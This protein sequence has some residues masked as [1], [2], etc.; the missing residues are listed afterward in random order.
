MFIIDNIAYVYIIFLLLYLQNVSVDSKKKHHV[1]DW[2]NLEIELAPMDSF[3]DV[4]STDNIVC[5]TI[6]D[7]CN[8][9]VQEFQDHCG[10]P[11]SI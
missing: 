8:T 10:N 9:A 1:I 4:N 11:L 7:N 5:D 3:E 6:P 2:D